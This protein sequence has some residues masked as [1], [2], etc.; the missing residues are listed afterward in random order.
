MTEKMHIS[1]YRQS[2]AHREGKYDPLRSRE[3]LLHRKEIDNLSNLSTQKGFTIIPLEVL[4]KNNFVKMVIGVCRG[5]KA[6]DKR[7]VLKRRAETKEVNQALKK[8]NR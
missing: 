7:D 5:K 6:H 8:F 1:P 2:A 3:L 4:L